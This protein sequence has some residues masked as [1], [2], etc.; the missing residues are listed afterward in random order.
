MT[1]EEMLN[2]LESQID[3]YIIGVAV[4][5]KIIADLRSENARFREALE[6]IAIRNKQYIFQETSP[7]GRAVGSEPGPYAKVAMKA[8]AGEAGN[9]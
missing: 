5:A 9:A 4:D 1:A 2:Y 3:D 7:I 6:F 8:L